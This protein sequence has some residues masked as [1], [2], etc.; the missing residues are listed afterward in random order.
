[1]INKRKTLTM[2]KPF[3]QH[4][5][6]KGNI[7]K[8]T[9]EVE[10]LNDWLRG[11][12]HEVDMVIGAGPYSIYED[13]AGNEGITGVVVLT[14]SHA[15]IHIWDAED[16]FKFQ[17]DIYSCKKYEIQTVVDYLNKEFELLDFDWIL[18]DR[19]ERMVTTDRGFGSGSKYWSDYDIIQNKN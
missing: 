11:L 17:F 16:P 8:T 4:L 14:T 10:V 6:I 9:K 3:H 2:F 13:A 18:V 15:S 7:K 19:N 12:V 1:M 5:L